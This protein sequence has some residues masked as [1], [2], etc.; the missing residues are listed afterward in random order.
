MGKLSRT[1]F[2][3]WPVEKMTSLRVLLF[4]LLC[5]LIFI[6]V[7]GRVVGEV[8]EEEVVVE[9]EGILADLRP[10]GQVAHGFHQVAPPA[11]HQVDRQAVIL[12]QVDH[13][14]VILHQVDHQADLQVDHHITHHQEAGMPQGQENSKCTGQS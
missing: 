7:E 8:V 4:I 10:V 3:G 2:A 14:A 9:A 12:H 11:V 6:C 13:Q 1:S 5:Y